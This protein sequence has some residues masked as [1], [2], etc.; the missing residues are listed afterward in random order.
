MG[1]S[2]RT[3]KAKD[4]LILPPPDKGNKPV[5]ISCITLH[6]SSGNTCPQDNNQEVYEE[7]SEEEVV[8]AKVD[9]GDDSTDSDPDSENETTVWLQ[10]S[11]LEGE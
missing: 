8:L 7:E 4:T 3:R 11:D 10:A 1:F 2:F 9:S 6:L 5:K